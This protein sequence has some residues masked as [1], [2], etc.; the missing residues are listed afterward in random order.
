MP[1]RGQFWTLICLVAMLALSAS[2]ARAQEKFTLDDDAEWAKQPAPDPESPAGQLQ[3]IRRLLAEGKGGEAGKRAERWMAQ[4]P[5][6][7]L[8]VEAYL[9]RGDAYVMKHDYYKSLYEYEKVIRQFPGSEQ[10]HTALR[11]ELEIARLFAAGMKRKFIGLRVIPTELE[12]EEIFIR[13]QERSPGSEI[14]EKAS[15]GLAD[16]YYDSSEMDTAIEAYDLFLVNY[17]DSL[18]RERALLRLIQASLATFKGP[19]FD[20]TGLIEAAQRLR[21]FQQEY[22]ASAEKVGAEALLVRIEES[23]AL[24]TYFTARWY[25]TRGEPTSAAYMYRRVV[26]DYPNTGAAKEAMKELTALGRGLT[27]PTEVN[28]VVEPAPGNSNP[29]A[30]DLPGGEPPASRSPA[31]RGASPD[32]VAP[33][34]DAPADDTPPPGAGA[35]VED[36][37]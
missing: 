29:S 17:P 30:S 16:Y 15:L 8:L 6:H 21:Q 3:T 23:L 31:G 28:P 26:K 27:G 2:P 33:P 35:G 4:Y 34:S 14:G 5:N 1:F 19:Q 12:A 11:R 18:H 37:P 7:P 9:L 13:I 25:Q 32:A 22:P 20:S 36:Q 10:F 24:K